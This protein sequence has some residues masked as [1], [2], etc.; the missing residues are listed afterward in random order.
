[1]LLATQLRS[2]AMRISRLARIFASE[3]VPLLVH[4]LARHRLK[5]TVGR[6]LVYNH[7]NEDFLRN[8]PKIESKPASYAYQDIVSILLRRDRDSQI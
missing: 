3:K 7:R 1:M 2:V 6:I 4:Y 5:C 8:R